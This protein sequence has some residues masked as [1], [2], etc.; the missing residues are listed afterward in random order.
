MKPP[1]KLNE[2]VSNT[3]PYI[4]L[5]KK[6]IKNKLESAYD[7][8]PQKAVAGTKHTITT[9]ENQIIHRKRVSK[10]LKS[11]FQNPHSRRRENPRGPDGHFTSATFNQS[12]MTADAKQPIRES[13]RI[14]EESMQDTT[15]QSPT[16]K[17]PVYGRG[18]GKLISDRGTQKSSGKSTCKCIWKRRTSRKK[19]QQNITP[20]TEDVPNII[21]VT[22]ENGNID[23]IVLEQLENTDQ[24]INNE[25]TI[26]KST[27]I[28]AENPIIRYGNPITD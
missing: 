5:E 25:L 9:D 17:S 24:N 8:K 1:R 10:S 20:T 3:F 15:M 6:V 4:F 2:D 14:L 12:E 28:K 7:T 13:T 18:K 19:I 23:L 26:R 21:T 22:D 11:P 16:E 27:R